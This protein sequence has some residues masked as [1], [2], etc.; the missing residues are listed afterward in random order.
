M[1]IVARPVGPRRQA[2]RAVGRIRRVVGEWYGL[3]Q[4]C[5]AERRRLVRFQCLRGEVGWD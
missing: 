1:E 4:A 3:Q 5:D 2:G